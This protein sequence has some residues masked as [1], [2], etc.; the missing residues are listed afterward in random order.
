VKTRR[1]YQGKYRYK[2]YDSENECVLALTT[3][4]VQSAFLRME[5]IENGELPE[6]CKL[7]RLNKTNEA[8]K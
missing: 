2:L 7:C 6:R 1:G 3:D 4:E 8:S 5:L